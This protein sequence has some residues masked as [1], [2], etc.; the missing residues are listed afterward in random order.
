MQYIID[1]HNLIPKIPGLKLSDPEDE[2]ALIDLLIPFLRL[3]R[4]RAKVFFDHAAEGQSGER[5][6][7]LLKA[8]F[9][10]AGKSAD[11]AIIGHIQKLGAEARNQ[12]LVSSDRMIQAAARPRYMKIL[13][14]EDF[15][16]ELISKLSE[17]PEKTKS[18]EGLTV[19]EI[20]E[21]EALF[22]QYGTTP[23]GYN[24]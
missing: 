23:D 10:P 9:V 17:N 24:P 20:E 8:V 15:A 12:C 13:K 4:S 16:D 19:G 22:N 7:G 18:F 5:N 3:T 2:K 11:A 1:G 14:S 21:W 6:F